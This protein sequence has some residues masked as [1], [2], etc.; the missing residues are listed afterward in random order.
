MEMRPPE[1][2]LLAKA[3]RS[4]VHPLTLLALA[5]LLLND[6][7]LRRLWPSLLTGKLGDFAWLFF[8][9][10][11]LIA[12]LAAVLPR[13]WSGRD[14][15]VPIFAYLSVALVFGLAKTLPPAHAL[16]VAIASRV[17]GFPVGWRLDPTDLIALL[18]LVA[19]ALLWVYAPL[20]ANQQ[21]A[22]RAPETMP[23]GGWAALVAAVLLTVAN[24]PA[25]DPGIYC[26]D[27][28]DNQLDAYAGYYTFRST[29][30]GLTWVSL[31]NQG[32]SA[33][34]NPW[35]S[36][37]GASRNATD[38]NDPQRQYRITPGENI[39]ESLD[40][41][42]TWKVVYK[43][44]KVSEATAA[45]RRRQLSSY[46]MVRPVPLDVKVDPA[47]GNAVFAM[48][49]SGVLVQEKATG[50]WQEAAVGQY[51]PVTVGG[52]ADYLG[53]LMGEVLLGIALMLLSFATLTTRVLEHARVLWTVALVVAWLAWAADVFLFPPAMTSGYGAALTYGAMLV[54]GVILLVLTVIAIVASI[55]HA[56]GH[57]G[58]RVGRPALVS[59]VAGLLFLLPYALWA[60]NVLPEYLMAQLLGTILAV[61][62]IV[63]GARWTSPGREASV[64]E[65]QRR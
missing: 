53:L 31:P 45:A 61:T 23:A 36:T 32:R 3:L 14:R 40:G 25:P 10:L 39:E 34:P 12:I 6:H 18:S 27:A 8:I 47:T 38:P 1:N 22:R 2:P 52:F 11:P 51:M 59:V 54:L 42:A 62:A 50:A 56:G 16:V 15:V 46:A 35:D 64:L 60:A 19:S 58:R 4:L 44:P 7:L 13:R 29:D 49:H 37:T 43:V 63:A 17:F 57:F 24:S 21:R 9:P 48:G 20:R 30:G 41:G 33:C 26:L 5:L 65:I 55:Q 28:Q